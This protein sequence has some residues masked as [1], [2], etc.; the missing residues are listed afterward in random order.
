M[1]A[2]QAAQL[3]FPAPPSARPR[4][5]P[6]LIKPRPCRAQVPPSCPPTAGPQAPGPSTDHRTSPRRRGPMD[7]LGAEGTRLQLMRVRARLKSAPTLPLRRWERSVNVLPGEPR[8]VWHPRPQGWNPISS[9]GPGAP[10]ALT[11]SRRCLW[12][13]PSSF[14]E[15]WA[16]HWPRITSQ[17]GCCRASA[18]SLGAGGRGPRWRDTQTQ[19]DGK[20]QRD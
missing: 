10:G 18:R 16:M 17:R 4:P 19:K 13:K 1:G 9:S 15:R 11:P 8:A 12:P 5:A 2:S 7:A 14:Q 20:R 3:P 6:R